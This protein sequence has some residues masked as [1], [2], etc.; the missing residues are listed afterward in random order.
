M[1]NNKTD[2]TF[3]RNEL[4]NLSWK[5]SLYL[6]KEIENFQQQD[7]GV[8]EEVKLTVDD[9]GN[10]VTVPIKITEEFFRPAL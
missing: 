1:L 2:K 8:V 5:D 10:E 4:E 7:F 3:I 6:I 9:K